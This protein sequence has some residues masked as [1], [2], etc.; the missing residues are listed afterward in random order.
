M[1]TVFRLCSPPRTVIQVHKRMRVAIQYPDTRARYPYCTAFQK[2]THIII[3]TL[4]SSVKTFPLKLD[5]G[6]NNF[7]LGAFTTESRRYLSMRSFRIVYADAEK[8]RSFAL[9]YL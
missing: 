3:I 5:S 8:L 4:S 9:N 6:T 7:K 2:I 1:Q